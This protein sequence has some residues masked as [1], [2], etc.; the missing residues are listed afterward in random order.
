MTDADNKR[1]D[2]PELVLDD[3]NKE[4]LEELMEKD[5]KTGRELT[6]FWYILTSAL[7]IIMVLF[8]TYSAGVLSVDTQYFLGTY[9]LLTFVMV[10]LSYPMTKKS[11][12]DRP[13]I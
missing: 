2:E 4:V 9:V 11:C 13:S 3:A 1:P 10:F 12:T 7:G 8:Y 5:S 6:S